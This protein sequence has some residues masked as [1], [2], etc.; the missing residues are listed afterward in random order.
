MTIS[1][2]ILP[3]PPLMHPGP[4]P[5]GYQILPDTMRVAGQ[6]LEHD[7]FWCE[8]HHKWMLTNF[9]GKS[10][11]H[12]GSKL[13]PEDVYVRRKRDFKVPADQV[14]VTEP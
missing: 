8:I 2:A 5:R 1:R 14:E 10:F 4:I 13:M 7:M 9:A 11:P 12:H 6:L 3:P